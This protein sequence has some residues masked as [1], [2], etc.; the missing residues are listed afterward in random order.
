M[1]G[2][3]RA[4]RPA[5]SYAL[6]TALALALAL[7][8]A[9]CASSNQAQSQPSGI[10]SEGNTVAEL[11]TAGASFNFRKSASGSVQV[12]TVQTAAANLWPHLAGVYEELSIPV[13]IRNSEAGLLGAMNFQVTRKLGD[14][15]LSLYLRC[16][17][18][19][20]GSLA[21]NSQIMMTVVTQVRDADLSGL[22]SQ[23]VT[24]VSGTARQHGLSSSSTDCDSTGRLEREILNRL[25]ITMM[26]GGGG[27]G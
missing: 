4:P 25:Q 20:T 7:G 21:D 22:A 13:E 5:S 9:A 8:A 10:V 19:I 16:G 11:N 26:K 12:D 6:V 1:I 15:R 23:V 14:H 2:N 17:S 3:L 27:G 18:S 24:L